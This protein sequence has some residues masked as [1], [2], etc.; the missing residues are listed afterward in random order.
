MSNSGK[1]SW[2]EHT[3]GPYKLGKFKNPNYN[4]IAVGPTGRNQEN[5]KKFKNNLPKTNKPSK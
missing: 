2:E 5:S 1:K 4:G 3:F